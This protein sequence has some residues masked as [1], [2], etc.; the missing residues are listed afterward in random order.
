MTIKLPEF[1]QSELDIIHLAFGNLYHYQSTVQDPENAGETIANPQTIEEFVSDKVAG[2]I[3][4]VVTENANKQALASVTHIDG[5][6]EKLEAERA[7][8]KARG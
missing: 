4:N 7:E 6:K 5:V 8:I 3:D 1:T 2:F